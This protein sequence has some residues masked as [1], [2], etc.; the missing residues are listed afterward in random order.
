MN[1]RKYAYILWRDIFG[2]GE[3]AAWIA[4]HDTEIYFI[5][6]HPNRTFSSIRDG[7][8]AILAKGIEKYFQRNDV[9]CTIFEFLELADVFL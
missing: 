9:R 1:Q 6:Y 4:A 3:R 8:P 5:I 2:S 7:E